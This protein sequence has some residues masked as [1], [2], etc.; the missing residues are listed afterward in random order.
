MKPLLDIYDYGVV[1]QLKFRQ[2]VIGYRGVIPFD[3]LHFNDI[4]YPQ[5]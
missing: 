5:L 3:C 1:M 2:G 4:F